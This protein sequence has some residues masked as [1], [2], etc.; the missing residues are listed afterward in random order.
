[1]RA[2]TRERS[3]FNEEERIYCF[4]N[5]G[6]GGGEAKLE[7]V[8]NFAYAVTG[9]YI[10][11]SRTTSDD[12]IWQEPNADVPANGGRKTFGGGQAG[13]VYIWLTYSNWGNNSARGQIYFRARITTR[14]TV[15]NMG[16]ISTEVLY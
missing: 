11:S 8:N 12:P 3:F 16:Y 1:V 6:A 9:I 14:V 13:Q 4:G 2:G 15:D 7:V 5:V 10:Y